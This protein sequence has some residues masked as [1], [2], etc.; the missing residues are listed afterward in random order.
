MVLGCDGDCGGYRSP[1]SSKKANY[2]GHLISV[3]LAWHPLTS[4]IL[5]FD[6][7]P[8]PSSNTT[9]TN[10]MN[11]TPVPPPDENSL[12]A[13]HAEELLPPVQPP[14]AN[15]LMKLFFIPM[16]IV[17]II[18]LVWFMFSWIARSGSHPEDMIT[19]LE[20]LDH[21]SW[22]HALNLANFLRDPRRQDLRQ[23]SVLAN[24]LAEVLDQHLTAAKMDKDHIRLRLFLCRALG[25]FEVID[26]LP[27]LIQAA[28]QQL[29]PSES[30]A[31]RAAVQAIAIMA[32][33]A[34]RTAMVATPNLVSTL[35]ELSAIDDNATS[36]R[37]EIQRLRSSAVF[38][39]GMLEGD[40]VKDQLVALLGDAQ[41]NVRFNAAVGLAR[42]GDQRA[43]PLLLR[44]LDP[45]NEALS[46]GTESPGD[47]RWKQEHV[48]GNAIR[49]TVKLIQANPGVD[50]S[51]LVDSLRNLDDADVTTAVKI[52]AVEALAALPETHT[53]P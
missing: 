42:Q 36:D 5:P 31:R 1:H 35:S 53:A 24:R 9:Q 7:G 21:R 49:A 45:N 32:E 50:S 48:L 38:A 34:D 52:A 14:T 51:E 20:R 18:V 13:I 30:E 25:E 43:V 23:D 12:R 28:T 10:R 2:L 37:Q 47:E 19:D 41:P 3:A 6:T 15:F 39:L 11:S 33:R 4:P 17:T 8:F 27:T 26:G 29:E 16:M 40:D 22:S 46:V 44:M